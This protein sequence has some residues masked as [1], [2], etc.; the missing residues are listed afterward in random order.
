MA[1]P[2]IEDRISMEANHGSSLSQSFNVLNTQVSNGESFSLQLNPYPTLRYLLDYSNNTDDFFI[3]EIVDLFNRSGGTNGGFRVR[4]YLEYTTNNSTGAPTA[5][6]QEAV[7]LIDGVDYQIVTWYGLQGNPESNRRRILKPE[8]DSALVAIAGVESTTGFSVDYTTGVITFTDTE[9]DITAISKGAQAV[10]SFLS[11][12]YSI[13]DTVVFSDV[14]GMIEINGV[15][16]TVLAVSATSITV[17]VNTSGFTDYV[18]GGKTNTAPKSEVV[19]AGCIF[20]VPMRFESDLTS[21]SFS[22]WN[23]VSSQVNLVEILN[24]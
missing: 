6:D 4:N 13:G 14:D 16:G 22:Q 8:V 7:A 23:T 1:R 10:V 20:D 3:S 5:L 12:G 19:T 15:R 18:S 11:N 2:F 17:D 21:A 24:L 9:D